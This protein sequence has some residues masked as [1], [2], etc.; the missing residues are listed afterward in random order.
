MYKALYA[1]VE[2]FRWPA[3]CIKE[4]LAIP[5]VY[6]IYIKRAFYF[7]EMLEKNIGF[8]NLS[9]RV[10]FCKVLLMFNGSVSFSTKLDIKST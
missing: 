8:L 9:P 10:T 6:P 5:L 2:F 3:K 4:F 7:N 1:L